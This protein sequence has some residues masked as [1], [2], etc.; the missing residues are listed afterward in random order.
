[1]TV[2]HKT[3]EFVP[4]AELEKCVEYLRSAV[5]RLCLMAGSD[6]QQSVV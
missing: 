2:A 5:E 1:M 6:Q 4:A 3:G